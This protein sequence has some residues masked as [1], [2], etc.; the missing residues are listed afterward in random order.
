M[1]TPVTF[2]LFSRILAGGFDEHTHV[3]TPTAG[4]QFFGRTD[5]GSYTVF[6][7]NSNDL[8]IEIIRANLKI[9]PLVPRGGVARFG[10]SATAGA[11]AAQHNDMQF[12]QGTT[13]ARK[14]PMLEEEANLGA[15]Q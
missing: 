6:S 10:G 8:D 15:D 13:F 3:F 5:N 12:N 11:A 4:Q 7:P 14:Y 1:A 9:A 2:D